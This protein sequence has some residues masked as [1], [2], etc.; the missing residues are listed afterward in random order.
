MAGQL[1]HESAFSDKNY[2]PK[3]LLSGF[4]MPKWD[5]DVYHARGK[6]ETDPYESAE[7]VLRKFASNNATESDYGVFDTLASSGESS[8]LVPPV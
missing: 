4:D 1:I 3:A 5:R 6:L 8:H 7:F 2:S